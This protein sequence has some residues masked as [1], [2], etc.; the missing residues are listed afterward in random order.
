MSTTIAAPFDVPDRA[1]DA[2]RV[3][4]R[5]FDGALLVPGDDGYEDA[6][7]G[8]N[9]TIE[10]RPAA[11]AI[12]TSPSDVAAAARAAHDHGLALAVQSTGHGAVAAADGALLLKTGCLAHIEIDPVNGSARVGPGVVWDEVNQAAAA[13]GLGSLA[14]RCASVGVTGYTLGGGTG[15]LSRRFGYA[16]DHI[17][18]AELVTVDGRQVRASA[19]EHADLFWALRGGGGNFGIVTELAFRLFPAPAIWGGQSFYPADRA[20]DVFAV[21]RDWAPS[22]PDE[23]NSAV[24]VMRL[25]A[26]PAVPEPLRSRQVLAVRAFH[27]GDER[28]GRRALAP[29]LDAAGRPLLNGFAT[30]PFPAASA[31]ANGP[32]VPPIALRQYVEFFHNLPDDALAAAATAGAI[33]ASPLAFVELRH[34]G[35]AISRPP[36]DAGPAGAR[37]VPFSVMAVAPYLGPDRE[38]VDAHVDRL[39][40]RLAPFATGEAFLN[41][42]TD[43]TR[44]ADAFSPADLRRL[45][46]VKAAWD[47]DNVLRVHHNISPAPAGCDPPRFTAAPEPQRSIR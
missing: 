38:P 2:V 45:S 37:T 43:P 33:P 10:S 15:W 29:L 6:R 5:R 8:W 28:S 36:L 46:R 18:H 4:R 23:M 1:A 17:L 44:T 7:R 25:P 41:M 19:D 21:Y 16:A 34:W 24:L 11:I 22:E 47:P 27:L 35:G 31:A 40:G 13:F 12:A 3:L 9:R 30:R 32:D 42:L 20:A 26:A 39:A 14:G